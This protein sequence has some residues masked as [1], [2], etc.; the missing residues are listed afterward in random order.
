[1]GECSGHTCNQILTPIIIGKKTYQYF[2]TKL[3]V[4]TIFG[5]QKFFYKNRVIMK[6]LY[7]N[8]FVD[9]RLL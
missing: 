8:Y 5:V 4:L 1:M 6:S 9:V 7:K 3:F 2:F